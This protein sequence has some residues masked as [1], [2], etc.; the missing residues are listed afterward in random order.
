MQLVFGQP[1]G[2]NLMDGTGRVRPMVCPEDLGVLHDLHSQDPVGYTRDGTWA[3][4]SWSTK[5]SK[6]IYYQD[7]LVVTGT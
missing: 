2:W 5:R 6:C 1:Y 4:H 7:C 3:Q